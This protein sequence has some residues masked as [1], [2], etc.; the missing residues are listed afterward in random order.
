MSNKSRSNKVGDVLM[1]ANGKL[2]DPNNED[3][4]MDDASMDG[5]KPKAKK[6]SFDSEDHSGSSSSDEETK[7]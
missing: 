7:Q 5:K 3:T 4:F 6:D 2:I 1:T